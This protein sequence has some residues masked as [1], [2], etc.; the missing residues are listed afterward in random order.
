MN[1]EETAIA[2]HNVVQSQLDYRNIV[3]EKTT[4]Q[5]NTSY[6]SCCQNRKV[7]FVLLSVVVISSLIVSILIP[8]VIL[9]KK[10]TQSSS[11]TTTATSITV[12]QLT[13]AAEVSSIPITN[14]TTKPDKILLNAVNGK[15]YGV[16]NT[17]VGD[18]SKASKPGNHW[19]GQYLP[20][21]SPEKACDGDIDTKYNSFG[22]CNEGGRFSNC[23]INTGFYLELEQ[24]PT[25][26]N[27]LRLW[28]GNDFAPRDPIVVSLEGSNQSEDDLILGSSWTLLYNGS[29]G[30]D[31]DP[32]RKQCG[33][34]QYLNNTIEYK[35]YRFLV[36]H[37]R[38]PVDCVQF[39]EIELFSFSS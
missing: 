4:E 24:G 26:V 9:K 12:S 15:V 28:T 38:A 33:L 2:N 25:I 5:Q 10:Q 21:E 37:S 19:S 14:T 34:M 36:L 31:I 7:L 22:W 3:T 23:A 18:D 35:S 17:S 8:T 6:K 27:G 29:S 13:T 30:L 11:I 39:S 20:E 16:W 1:T 32:G